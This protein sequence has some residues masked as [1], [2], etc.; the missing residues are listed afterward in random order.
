MYK[1]EFNTKEEWKKARLSCLT[2]T[3]VGKYI[4]ITSPYAPKSDEEMAKNP[5]VQF[6]VNCETSILTIFSNLPSVAKDL[7]L[8]PT[9]KPTLWYSDEDNRIA[10]SFDA[11]AY[12]K[13]QNGFAE[14]KSTSAGL[15]DLKNWVIPNTTWLQIIHYF[16]LDDSLQF[17]Y[18][19]VCSY[20]KW[21]D[22]GAK[23]DYVR[24]SRAMVQSR[25][26]NLK[27]WHKYILS[28]L[29]KT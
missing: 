17:C 12:E 22:W 4:G 10:G 9:I 25:I 27:S 8:K 13:G 11:L 21:G 3:T 19:V 26:D 24:I 20:H 28:N 16:S 23:I 2:G 6:G 29:P 7:L 5:A 15:Y 1:V 18:L 14:C